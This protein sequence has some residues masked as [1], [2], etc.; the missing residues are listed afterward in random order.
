MYKAFIFDV[1]GTLID[2]REFHLNSWIRAFK[3]F[4]IDIGVDEVQPQFGRRAVEIAYELLPGEMKGEARQVADEKRRIF[5]THLPEVKAFPKT[6]D[7]LRLLH[8]RSIKIALATSTVRSEADY[9]VKMMSIDRIVEAVVTAE[10]IE[11]SKPD[12]E[13]FLKAAAR[14]NVSPLDSIGVGDSPH[15]MRAIKA[16]GMFAIGVLTGGYDREELLFAG[17]DRIYSGMSDLFADI[18]QI[19]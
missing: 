9:Y 11:R 5:A 7:L 1:D 8:E 4:G 17:A 14:L 12:P 10:D 13:I 18:E 2:T 19:L 6:K 16:A 15:D 3:N